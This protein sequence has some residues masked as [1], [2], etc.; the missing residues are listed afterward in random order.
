MKDV[1]QR[2]G[3]N[4][5]AGEDYA[6]P[7]ETWREHVARRQRYEDIWQK[8]V[9]GEV[10]SID[11]LIT[12]N[13]NIRQ[14]AQDVIH[15]AEGPELVRAFLQGDRERRGAGSDLRL[16]RVPVRGAEH[17]R[18]ALRCLPGA[19]GGAGRRA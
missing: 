14:F 10:S 16:R 17:P 7:T 13:L 12:Y 8:L 6:L 19:D 3:W 15:H 18:A 5:P 4:R 11:D 1:S 2:A 9:G